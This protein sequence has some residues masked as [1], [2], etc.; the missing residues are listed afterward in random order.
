MK[1]VIGL[2]NP[3]PEYDSHRHNVGWWVVD[4]LAFDWGFGAFKRDGGALVSEGT[5]CDTRVRLLK[6]TTYMNRSGLA[7][8][9][10][11]GVPGFVPGEDLLV[12]VDDATLEVGRVRFRPEGSA[13][14]HN[15]LKSISGA[16]QSNAFA[17]LRV[18]V[19]QKPEGEDLADWVLSEM[20]PEDEDVVVGLLPELTEA[21][22][23]WVDEGVEAAMNRFNR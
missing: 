6:P 11:L 5:A 22:E 3:G 14:G 15:G 2:G 18:G 16:L 20:P 12:V 8:R 1:V 17:R 23:A 10:L 13:G 9:P 21:V 19:G 4:R 7:L